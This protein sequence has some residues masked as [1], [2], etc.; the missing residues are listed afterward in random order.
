MRRRVITA[1]TGTLLCQEWQPISCAW[2]TVLFIKHKLNDSK[3]ST[4][5]WAKAN[6]W[7]NEKVK[8]KTFEIVDT[9]SNEVVA[10]ATSAEEASKKKRALTRALPRTDAGKGVY[11]V[12]E[13]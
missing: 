6:A 13:I 1:S 5:D 7:L 2:K 9:R 10:R 3:P 8:E 12:R 11:E 4:Q